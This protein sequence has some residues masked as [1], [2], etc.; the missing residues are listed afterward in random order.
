MI[1]SDN[2]SYIEK[3]KK[4]STQSRENQIHYEHEEIGFNYRMSNILAAIGI[5][6]L[7]SIDEYVNK[8]RKIFK[9]YKNSFN[10][11]SNIEFMPEIIDGRSTNWLSV[12]ILK[13]NSYTEIKKIINIF[14]EYN[15][16]CRPI[17]KPMHMQPYYNECDFIFSEKTSVSQYL[18]E[19]GLC[20]PSGSDLLKEDQ[21]KIIQ[22]LKNLIKVL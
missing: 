21:F 19:H 13:E 15:V 4:L 8:T 12:M 20:L 2:K 5:G 1:L 14:E 10:N 7:N 6:Q 9:L 18:F 22:I 11:I 16:E 3:A 17:W